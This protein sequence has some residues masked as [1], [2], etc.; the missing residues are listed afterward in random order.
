MGALDDLLVSDQPKSNLDK[1]LEPKSNLDKLLETPEEKYGV[2]RQPTLMEKLRPINP[3]A[4]DVEQKPELQEPNKLEKAQQAVEEWQK[5]KTSAGGA[6]KGIAGGAAEFALGLPSMAAQALEHPVKTA[7]QLAAYGVAPLT[8]IGT[9]AAVGIGKDI[10]REGLGESIKS[11]EFT[12]GLTQA[13]L[14]ALLG[15]QSKESMETLRPELS[16]TIKTKTGMEA[17]EAVKAIKEN[18][19]DQ[20]FK[21]VSVNDRGKLH[22]IYTSEEWDKNDLDNLTDADKQEKVLAAQ[23]AKEAREQYEKEMGEKPL[24]PPTTQE[25]PTGELRRADESVA[26]V[27]KELVAAAKPSGP[28]LIAKGMDYKTVTPGAEYKQPTTIGLMNLDDVGQ[29]LEGTQTGDISK[30]SASVENRAKEIINNWEPTF[31][32]ISSETGKGAIV[33]TKGGQPITGASLTQALKTVYDMASKGDD[34][35]LAVLDSYEKEVLLPSVRR[36][37]LNITEKEIT[38]RLAKGEKLVLANVI[39]NELPQADLENMGRLAEGSSKV[40][41]SPAEIAMTDK[42][43]L[44]PEILSTVEVDAKGN[45]TA[46]SREAVSQFI[47]ALPRTEQKEFIGPDNKIIWDKAEERMKGAI[48]ASLTENKYTL[49]KVLELGDD[50]IKSAVK[51]LSGAAPEL[52]K[53]KLAHPEL[54]PH[55]IIGDALNVLDHIRHEGLK[56]DEYLN[57]NE[58]YADPQHDAMVK[59]LVWMMDGNIPDGIKTFKSYVDA[60]MTEGAPSLIPMPPRTVWDIWSK[61]MPWQSDKGLIK[62]DPSQAGFFRFP[63][64]MDPMERAARERAESIERTGKAKGKTDEEI[65]KMILKLSKPG[66]NAAKII[67]ERRLARKG[68]GAAIMRAMPKIVDQVKITKD[69]TVI[70]TENA[71]LKADIAK[72]PKLAPTDDLGNPIK[73]VKDLPSVKLSN[74]EKTVLPQKDVWPTTKFWGDSLTIL[75]RDVVRE[76]VRAERRAIPRDTRIMNLRSGIDD[77][78]TLLSK[79]KLNERQDITLAMENMYFDEDGNV[80]EYSGDIHN[81]NSPKEVLRRDPVKRQILDALT[82]GFEMARLPEYLNAPKIE[83]FE[84]NGY[85]YHSFDYV[86]RLGRKGNTLS[87]IRN[88]NRR[89]YAADDAIQSLDYWKPT[90][91][92]KRRGMPGWKIDNPFQIWDSYLK[93]G[94]RKKY[95]IPALGKADAIME[96]LPGNQ[97]VR[98]SYYNNWKDTAMGRPYFIDNFLHEMSA[99]P[100]FNGWQKYNMLSMADMWAA[101]QYVADIGLN[102]ATAVKHLSPVIFTMAEH[103]IYS[104][105]SIPRLGRDIVR[106]IG[107]GSKGSPL[108]RNPILLQSVARFYDTA[109]TIASRIPKSINSVLFAPITFAE[110]AKTGLNFHVYMMMEMDKL[111]KSGLDPQTHLKGAYERAIWNARE[112]ALSMGKLYRNE[113]I[114]NAVPRISMMFRQP[115]ASMIN[116]LWRE[117]HENPRGFASIAVALGGIW[118]MQSVMNRDRNWR[119]FLGEAGLWE[120]KPMVA[121]H[122]KLDIYGRFSPLKQAMELIKPSMATTE[123]DEFFNQMQL[124]KTPRQQ[125]MVMKKFGVVVLQMGGVPIPTSVMSA[126]K[127]KFKQFEP[128]GPLDLQKCYKI[129]QNRPDLDRLVVLEELFRVRT[130]PTYWYH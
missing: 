34:K 81:P 91:A 110:F 106:I 38:D 101:T 27:P 85:I 75:P 29:R 122:S 5:S 46:K 113:Y 48:L 124:A 60:A 1:L 104:A 7:A 56:V 97:P 102:L 77:A 103:P 18:P 127:L 105:M 16:D 98:R 50:R 130:R 20:R 74:F 8:T 115:P 67:E 129:M 28:P 107:E 66:E 30:L 43:I 52:L 24:A 126:G 44:T 69:A 90:W 76:V 41:K 99:P 62:P 79:L 118:T 108:T 116:L 21:K 35:A 36:W 83:D 42:A 128:L 72:D 70:N 17:D 94:M 95:I 33:L 111:A 121:G 58:L 2:L 15:R 57:Q 120:R 119:D 78:R 89:T 40:G 64:R 9:Q 54:M 49:E 22:D 86:D 71:E 55:E 125:D 11:G 23:T 45:F 65:D 31:A 59:G 12:A 112:H 39:K 61:Y 47:N 25:P 6:A 51:M 68:P 26:E 82:K 10:M 87:D 123:M 53:L 93:Q 96:R 117:V 4:S 13:A 100:K 73:D 32:D 92:N 14:M 114:R 88:G 63:G 109:E 3:F 80:K 19:A 37:G 84:S